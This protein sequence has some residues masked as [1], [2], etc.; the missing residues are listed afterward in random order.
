MLNFK[1]KPEFY[2]FVLEIILFISLYDNTIQI[3]TETK[4]INTNAMNLLI[5]N[6]SWN[7][8]NHCGNNQNFLSNK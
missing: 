3:N 4:I 8:P 7:D 6:V 1:N 5:I 2:Y